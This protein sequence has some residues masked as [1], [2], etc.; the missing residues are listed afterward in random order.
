MTVEPDQLQRAFSAGDGATIPIESQSTRREPDGSLVVRAELPG[1][2]PD[3]D[4]RL[5]VINRQLVI[6]AERRQQD[7]NTT[8]PLLNIVGHGTTRR[9][10]A[11][12]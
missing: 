9:S 12:L 10:R 3:R 4:I 2:D 5:T 11:M 6:E 8:R 1:V 7:T